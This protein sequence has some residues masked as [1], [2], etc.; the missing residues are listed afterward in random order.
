MPDQKHLNAL[1]THWKEH[2][3]FP[4]MAKLADVLG[5]AS[6]GGVFKVIG[7]LVDAGYLERVEGRIAPTRAFFA[8]PVMGQVRAGLPQEQDQSA[9]LEMVGVEDY[10]I[11]NPERTVFCRVRGDS[12]KDAGMLDGDM[13]VVE[14]NRPTKAGDIV[15]ALVDNELTVK[16]LHPLKGSGGWVLKPANPDYP[17]IVAQQSL[18]V[19][20]VVVGLFRRF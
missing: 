6:S 11:Q 1:R 18:E 5:L 12:M 9:G 20:G 4:S 19:L 14:R 16:Y 2:K 8:L 3:A 17:D 10:L 13:V 15:V 7:R